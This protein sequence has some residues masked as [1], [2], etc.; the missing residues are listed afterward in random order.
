MITLANNNCFA[1]RNIKKLRNSTFGFGVA[2][3]L[4]FTPACAQAPSAQIHNRVVVET[5]NSYSACFGS[6]SPLTNS[7]ASGS[8][9]LSFLYGPFS[10]QQYLPL[11]TQWQDG[12]VWD[13]DFLDPDLPGA[14]RL[15]NDTANFD[16]PGTAISFFQGHGAGL[17]KPSGSGSLCNSGDDCANPPA[18]TSVGNLQDG[19]CA[20]SPL[21][22]ARTGKGY[23]NYTSTPTLNTCGNFDAHGHKA[24]LSPGMALG[25]TPFRTAF[26]LWRPAG[27]NGGTSVAIVHMSFGMW[28]FFPSSEWA[29]LF[30]GLQLY[31]GLMV[32]ADDSE[33]S[34]SFGPA[35]GQAIVTNVLGSVAD[36]YLN[37][38]SSVTDGSGCKGWPGGFNGCGCHFAMTLSQGA[39]GASDNFNGDFFSLLVDGDSQFGPGYWQW[40]AV[41]NY[42]PVKYPWSGGDREG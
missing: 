33:D 26:G 23:C 21:S 41:C 34:A 16:Q 30:D 4:V 3:L 37:A 2:S 36:G 27:K 25:E 31:L 17:L 32:S 20:W 39:Q 19:T 10:L 7:N 18:G 8:G 38:M 24:A 14:N 29:G 11:V 9:F 12:N 13:T 6:S 42:D 35:V 15:D 22:V 28:T 5:V 1:R 40:G